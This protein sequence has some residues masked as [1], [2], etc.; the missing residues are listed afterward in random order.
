MQQE[1]LTLE[2]TKNMGKKLQKNIHFSIHNEL[3]CPLE[4]PGKKITPLACYRL[5]MIL[6]SQ[7]VVC[8]PIALDLTCSEETKRKERI[9]KK[10]SLSKG[11]NS[12]S[13]MNTVYTTIL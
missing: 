6:H 11:K 8:W 3:L 2:I 1:L 12:R 13:V 4:P 10:E 9:D 7:S 5:Y